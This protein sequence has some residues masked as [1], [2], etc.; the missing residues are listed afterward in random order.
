MYGRKRP[1]PMHFPEHSGEMAGNHRKLRG[2][3]KQY[4]RRK[5]TGILRSFS[6]QI[7][8]ETRWKASGKNPTI[9]KQETS[10]QKKLDTT[11]S[12]RETDSCSAPPMSKTYGRNRWVP[13]TVPLT[14]PVRYNMDHI[15]WL[16]AR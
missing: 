3:W 12:G 1:D 11:V 8:P 6:R 9:S 13:M 16:P 2:K 14:F 15:P 10:P 7:Q 4:S 5:L